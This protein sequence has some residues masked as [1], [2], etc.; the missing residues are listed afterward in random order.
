MPGNTLEHGDIRFTVEDE[1]ADVVVVLNYLKYDT[2]IHVRRGYVWNWHNEPIVRKP[3]AKGFDRVFTHEQS[4]DPRGETAPPI[5]DWWIGKTWDELVR[6]DPPKKTRNLSVIASNKSLIPGHRMRTEF[7]DLIELSLPTVDVFGEGRAQRLED[8]WD[9]LAPYKYSVAIENTSTPDYWTEKVSDCFLSF[10]VPVYFGAENL[11]SYFPKDSFIW[12]PLEN[13][14]DAID[15]L[16]SVLK[17]DS[18]RKRLP[19]LRE[20]RRLVLEEYSL[21]GQLSRRIRSEKTE[22]FAEPTI[23]VAVQGRRV[24]RGGWIRNYGARGNLEA[25]VRK[26]R[27]RHMS[28]D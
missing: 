11:E 5:L 13:P 12:L 18:W 28:R 24:K 2:V 23:P 19:A 14:K 3:F 7:V 22:I 4:D 16:R 27:Q 26:I 21:F 15:T 6:L 17:E 1:P 10:T 25:L 20:A 9:G 8:K